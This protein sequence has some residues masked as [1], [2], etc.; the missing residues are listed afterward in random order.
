MGSCWRPKT[1]ETEA[2]FRAEEDSRTSRYLVE[3]E[4]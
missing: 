4:S 3:Q 2:G 1:E